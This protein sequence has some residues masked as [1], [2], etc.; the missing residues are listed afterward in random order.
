MSSHKK[1]STKKRASQRSEEQYR[2]LFESVPHPIGVFDRETLA[3]L[4]V[5]EAAVRHYGYSREEFLAM[6]IKDVQP[7]GDAPTPPD[8]IEKCGQKVAPG[9][10]PIGSCKHRKKD[11]TIVDVEIMSSPVSFYGRKAILVLANDVTERRRFETQITHLTNHDPLTGLF[12]RHRFQEELEHQLAQTRYQTQ[13][14]LLSL[15]LDHFKDINDGLGHAAGDE[16]LA[17]LALL[18]RQRLRESDVVARMGGDE[19]IILLPHTNGDQAQTVAQQILKTI[20]H[21][22]FSIAGRRINITASIGVALFPKH[23]ATVRELLSHVDMAMYQ[24]KEI[25]R[26]SFS[27]YAPDKERKARVERRVAWVKRIHEALERKRLMLYCQPILDLKSNRISQYELLLRMESERGNVVLP[28][29][30]LDVAERFGFI[31]DIDRQ[32]VLQAIHLIAEHHRVGRD[33]HLEVNLSSK[34]FSDREL[35]ALIK[36]ELAV[37]GINP[38]N[39][40]LEIT[41][42]AA[43]TDLYQA[44]KFIRSLK[45]LGYRFGLDDFGVGFS[46]FYYLK[47]L[48]IDFLKIDG[49]FIRDLPHDPVDQHLVKAIVEIARALDKKIIAEFVSDKETVRLLQQFG[50]DYAQGYYIGRPRAVSETFGMGK[51]LRRP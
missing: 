16:L 45:R 6:T 14:A 37:T 22:S 28:G 19:F 41:E 23:G 4:A 36:H 31:H 30:F 18:L 51:K 7:L 27:P 3:F 49:S 9:V 26:N 11:G 15:D 21:H 12:N 2:R 35:L 24:A 43:I 34:A 42:T 46:S 13:G 17:E 44:E 1:A 32:V 8:C 5:N 47:H 40:V 38:A 39:L 29:A 50:V 20:R 48:P 33:L 10:H 25:G